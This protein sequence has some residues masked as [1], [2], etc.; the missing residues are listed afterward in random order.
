[1]L[2]TTSLKCL[3][4]TQTKTKQTSR[5]CSLYKLTALGQHFCFSALSLRINTKCC[6]E[7]REA[8]AHP[9]ATGKCSHGADKCHVC[10][11]S[12]RSHFMTEKSKHVTARCLVAARK[13]RKVGHKISKN[14]TNKWIMKNTAE[15]I[16]HC[17]D[18]L[19]LN[20]GKICNAR[21]QTHYAEYKI[22][23]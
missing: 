7:S 4:R 15:E 10:R 23:I 8:G 18:M 21:M 6:K 9:N 14:W 1:M 11:A 19:L 2:K 5:C 13:L 20:Q 22:N 12:P 17:S 16:W 3:Q